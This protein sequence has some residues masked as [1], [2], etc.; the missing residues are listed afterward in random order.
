MSG[1][2]PIMTNS[3]MPMPKPPRASGARLF[4]ITCSFSLLEEA[5]HYSG[6]TT[7]ESAFES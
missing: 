6:C 7:G 1:R 5:G 4:L 2:M 3:V